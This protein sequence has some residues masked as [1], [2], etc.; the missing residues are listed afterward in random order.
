MIVTFEAVEY[1]FFMFFFQPFTNK[2]DVIREAK[3]VA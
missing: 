2:K 1:K 3:R